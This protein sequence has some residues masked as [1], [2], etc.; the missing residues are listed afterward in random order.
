MA[1]VRMS[2][3]LQDQIFANARRLY[4]KRIEQASRF[5]MDKHVLGELIYNS[6]LDAS[7]H[8]KALDSLPANWVEHR[9]TVHY[10]SVN[11]FIPRELSMPLPAAMPMPVVL[12]QANYT[13][14][15]STAINSPALEPTVMEWRK[16]Q[17]NLETLEAE[18]G[19]FCKTV[20]QFMARH[21]TLRQALAEWPA[22]WELVPQ[23]Y[24]DR[25]NKAVERSASDAP[26]PPEF[27]VEQLTAKVVIA[28]VTES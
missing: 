23:H 28:K 21:T 15:N 7:G 1:T 27:D 14:G 5:F 12:R 11:G 13:P 8:R 26:D 25:H 16:W 4:A 20:A 9:D 19:E 22:F 3:E 18:Q 10:R 2:G 6:Y 17:S 24:R